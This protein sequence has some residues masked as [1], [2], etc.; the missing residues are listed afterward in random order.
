MSTMKYILHFFLCFP[1]AFSEVQGQDFG[2]DK[3]GIGNFIKRM[4]TASP[5]NGVK[6]F[7]SEYGKDYLVSVVELKNDPAKPE[8]VQ[9]RIASVKAKAYASQY[10]NGSNVST[11]VIVITTNE[12]LKDSV[13]S[14]TEMQEI[15]KES[16]TGFVDGMEM[17]TKF[18]SENKKQVVYI[19]YKKIKY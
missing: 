5:F 19:Y 10:L 4:Y 2:G 14:K 8:S 3:V 18:E 11:D 12:R 13:I 15:L 16:S 9:S 17:L 7:Q 6:L 1:L